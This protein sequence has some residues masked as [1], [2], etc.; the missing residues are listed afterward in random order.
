MKAAFQCWGKTRESGR[1]RAQSLDA[2]GANHLKD[3]RSFVSKERTVFHSVESRFC[4]EVIVMRSTSGPGLVPSS[5]DV[6]VHLVLDDFGKFG[7]AY[8]ETDEGKAK[9]QR[10]FEPS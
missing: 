10:S 6:T 4:T 7:R 3:W 8:L 1:R 2:T 9:G 5:F